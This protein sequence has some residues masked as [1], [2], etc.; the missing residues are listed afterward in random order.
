MFAFGV[1]LF[2]LNWHMAIAEVVRVLKPGGRLYGEE[3][4]A[5]FLE[6]RLILR[7]FLHPKHGRFDAPGLR[8]ALGNAWLTV[9]AWE[10]W[11]SWFAG[12]M[13][14]KPASCQQG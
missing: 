1:F 2:V 11:R 12:F 10:D 13:A 6:R 8:A 14:D 3:V 4:L 5:K 9:H 7:F